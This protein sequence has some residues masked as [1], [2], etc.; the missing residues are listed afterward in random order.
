MA[1]YDDS[2]FPLVIPVFNNPTY[3]KNF[4]KQVKEM[5][6]S[7]IEIYDNA[8][9]YPP[10][11]QLLKE[12]AKEPKV[13]IINLEKNAGPHYVLRTPEIYETMEEVF[14]LSDPDIEFSKSLPADFLEVLYGL[15]TKHKYGKVGFA[16]EVPIE[17]D[18]E[19]L[20]VRMDGTIQKMTDWEQ[21]FWKK[22]IAR[23][24]KGDP[25]YEAN[26]DTT[27]ALY[28][29]KYFNPQDRYRALRVAGSF[30]SK[31]LGF[32][33]QN[34][35]PKEE[36]DFYKG[37]NRFSYFSGKYDNLGNPMV[38]I[39]V[40]EYTKLVEALESTERDV[41][42]LTRS[43]NEINQQLQKVYNSKSW[44]LTKSLRNIKNLLFKGSQID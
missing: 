27:F 9:T 16:I 2:M 5:P 36:I 14:C 20:F 33:K 32:Y 34:S 3:L 26:I 22:E 43:R 28:N 40:H 30:V 39:S 42:A 41:A 4:Y 24:H 35:I 21:Q 7:R 31:H 18:F 17:E 15:T 19:N 29:K 23:T 44:K 37:Q 1:K 25:V 11:V 6:F 13:K 12:L 10:M 8:S 38:E